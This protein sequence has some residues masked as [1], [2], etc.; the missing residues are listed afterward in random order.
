MSQTIPIWKPEE[1]QYPSAGGFLPTL[2]PYLWDDDEVRPAVIVV[3]GGAYC[4]VS[5]SEGQI[6]AET[7]RKMGYQAFVL[8]YTT[9]PA[10]RTPLRWQPL[11]D[12]ARAVRIVREHAQ[13]W[14]V[15]PHKVAACGFSAGGHLV[16]SLAVYFD[17]PEILPSDTPCRLDAAILSY[18]VLTFGEYTH[19][20]TR[21]ALIGEP[22]SEEDAETMSLEKQVTEKTSPC[23]LWHTR[24][25]ESVPVQNSLFFEKELLEHGVNHAMYIFPRGR[26]GLSLSNEDWAQET[27]E[28]QETEV[29][30]FLEVE[31]ALQEGTFAT[32][33]PQ[34]T[35]PEDAKY[36]AIREAWREQRKLDISTRTSDQWISLWP[37][38]ANGFLHDVFK[39]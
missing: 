31:R 16:G 15:D 13:E 14:H 39:I 3:P 6:V 2:T 12:L 11:N 32:L 27:L 1:Y 38:L 36:D 17:R 7:F 18:P 29:Q 37:E 34:I 20:D 30:Y 24:N 21:H 10:F 5:S 9:N 26:H 22:Y 23:F 25:D 28:E 33:V 8:V 19:R 35:V 4:F